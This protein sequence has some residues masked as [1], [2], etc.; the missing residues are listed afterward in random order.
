MRSQAI[1]LY[2]Q[3]NHQQ[4][5]RDAGGTEQRNHAITAS[6][7]A[8]SE[9]MGQGDLQRWSFDPYSA[10]S[11]YIYIKHLYMFITLF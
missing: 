11:I 5:F 6:S 1:Y 9:L 8:E 7:R 3:N 2:D 4:K 10:K